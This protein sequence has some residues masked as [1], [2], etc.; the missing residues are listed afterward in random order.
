MSLLFYLD[1]SKQNR[2][3]LIDYWTSARRTSFDRRALSQT[4][5]WKSARVTPREMVIR[6]LK[7]TYSFL[8]SEILDARIN[9]RPTTAIRAITA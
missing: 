9:I 5:Y 6:L 7:A 4:M 8:S 1:L 3:V 2:T